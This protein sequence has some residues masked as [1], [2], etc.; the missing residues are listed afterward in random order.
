MR[1]DGLSLEE[2]LC[3][4]LAAIQESTS[5]KELHIKFPLQGGQ[6]YLALGNMLMHTQ[7]LQSLTLACPDGPLED[8]AVAA[9]RSGLKKNTTLRE[10]TLE[11]LRG[12]T[13]FP[14]FLTILCNHP[15]LRR[16]SLR[17]YVADL[18]GLET[19]LL[20]DTSKITE[21]DIY[22]T[23]RRYP[24]TGPLMGLTPV[25]QALAR[26]PTLTMLGL[27][28]CP[29]SRKEAKLLR[30]AL[31][32]IPSLQSL[33]LSYTDLGSDELAELAPA[34]YR[35]TSIKVLDLS[36]N[37]LSSMESVELLRGI[38]RRN[39][40]I[41][42]LDLSWNTFGETTGAVKSI[43]DGLDSNSRLLKINL[44]SCR[45]RDDGVCILMQTLG[46]RNTTLQKLSLGGNSI[47][48][49][50]VGLLL[51][52]MEQ[53]SQLITD[54][55]LR[56]NPIGNKGASLLARS[57]GKNAIP[58]LTHLSLYSCD[59]GDAGFIAL[60]SALEQ[61]T[62]L[63][64]L[65]LQCAMQH[66]NRYNKQAFLALAKSLPE[67]KV[68]QQLYLDGWYRGLSLAMP[69]VLAGLRKNTSLL[70]IHVHNGAPCSF[71]PSGDDTNKCAGGWIQEM[72][73]L[74]YRNC[75]L[76][77]IRA[78]KE[79]LPH[80][81]VWPRALAQVAAHPDVIFEV[82]CSKPKLVPSQDTGGE[83]AAEDSGIPKKSKRGDE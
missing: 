54:L 64:Q 55:D 21:L 81:G 24:M 74:G 80:H 15:L 62:S 39:K 34:L 27:H 36:G 44:S 68:L 67:I 30:T 70:C 66:A 79:R 65:D 37:I 32:M 83:E 9:A 69:L 60:V 8:M 38:M 49:T 53:N 18:S 5:L 28:N 23:D 20:S 35:N 14:P 52:T 76:P 2:L 71:P 46:S 43:A 63:L 26:R 58:N 41:T 73:R 61:N 10:L 25:L 82:L 50:G 13:I 11:F 22:R 7:S 29:L 51:G 12:A 31:C 56:F 75:F 40:S 6:S 59:I 42:T 72:Q 57:M 48:S 47:T 17:G 1:D 19:V 33:D 4:F 16:V 77:L 45:L 78:P 3:C